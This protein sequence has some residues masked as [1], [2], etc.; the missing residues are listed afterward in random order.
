M[1][2]FYYFYPLISTVLL[3][4]Y[5][6]GLSLSWGS[7]LPIISLFSFG[8]PLPIHPPYG[9]QNNFPKTFLNPLLLNLNSQRREHVLLTFCSPLCQAKWIEL[10]LNKCL[11]GSKFAQNIEWLPVVCRIKSKLCFLTLKPFH[12]LLHQPYFSLVSSV[13]YHAQF[14]VFPFSFPW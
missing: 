7:A 8:T 3:D 12:I 14:L 4:D 6:L 11:N 5:L 2:L 13:I 10:V 9:C 1:F